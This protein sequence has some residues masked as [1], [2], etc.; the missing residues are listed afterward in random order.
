MSSPIDLDKFMDDMSNIPSFSISEYSSRL[1]AAILAAPQMEKVSEFFLL[2]DG[3][4]VHGQTGCY[5]GGVDCTDKVNRLGVATASVVLSD[6]GDARGS[7]GLAHGVSKV[8][9]SNAVQRVWLTL[10]AERGGEVQRRYDARADALALSR[11]CE[12]IS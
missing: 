4:K 11:P 2:D 7:S 5:F 12:P 3:D 6:I 1:K 10:D 9:D 8:L